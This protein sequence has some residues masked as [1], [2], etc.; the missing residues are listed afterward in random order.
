MTEIDRVLVPF[1]GSTQSERA[2]EYVDSVFPAADVT[3]LTAI[4]PVDGFA[5]YE[6]GEG[7][8]ER[9]A[10]RKAESLLAE[11]ET[12]LNDDDRA[13]ATVVEIGAPAETIQ[14]AVTDHHIDHVVIGSHGRSGLQRILVGS[15]AESVTRAVSVPVTI[16][17]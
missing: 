3:L 11:Q 12:V 15:V 4:D 5:G 2:V 16:V 14:S 17:R 9:Q 6:G 1:D 10:T 7:N 13:V 8:W